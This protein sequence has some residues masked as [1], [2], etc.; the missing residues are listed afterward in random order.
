MQTDLTLIKSGTF[1]PHT[2]TPHLFVFNARSQTANF[3]EIQTGQT[4]GPAFTGTEGS[5]ALSVC[6][7][8]G[9]PI[10]GCPSVT[11]WELSGQHIFHQQVAQMGPLAKWVK[12][13]HHST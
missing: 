8:D 6:S 10:T 3:V 4:A 9:S 5:A 1:N 7:E 13:V 2:S 12:M 11:C